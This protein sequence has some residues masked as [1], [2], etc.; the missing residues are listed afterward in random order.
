MVSVK[1]LEAKI[2]V[3]LYKEIEERIRLGLFSTESEVIGKAL[4][5]SFAEEAREF[6]RKLIKNMGISEKSLLAEWKRIRH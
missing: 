1:T 2:P 4:R 3:D 5:K 6:L